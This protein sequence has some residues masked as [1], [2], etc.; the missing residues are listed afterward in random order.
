MKR[1]CCLDSRETGRDGVEPDRKREAHW[2]QHKS[3]KEANRRKS[4][5]VQ[6]LRPSRHQENISWENVADKVKSIQMVK[7]KRD[8]V[9]SRDL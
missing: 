7:S 4:N 1:E 5:R 8:E 6:L 9:Q 2:C 3:N